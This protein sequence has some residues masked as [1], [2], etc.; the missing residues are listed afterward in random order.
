MKR[1]LY[2]LLLLPCS[3]LGDNAWQYSGQIERS[4]VVTGT[5]EVNPDGSVKSYTL[6]QQDKLLPE[7]IELI[8]KAVPT[9]KFEPMADKTTPATAT[10]NI[11][12]IADK[13]KEDQYSL[14]ICGVSFGAQHENLN[15]WPHY[16]TRDP[17]PRYPDVALQRWVSGTVYVAVLVNRQGT[18]EKVDAMRVD[19]RA[20]GDRQIMGQLRRSLAQS[21]L[22]AIAKWTFTVPT[23]GP[24]VN[25]DHWMVRI[26]VNFKIAGRDPDTIPYGHWDAYVPGPVNHVSWVESEEHLA[27]SSADAIPDNDFAFQD[28]PRFVLLNAPG[29]G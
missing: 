27:E 16:K 12:V 1:L 21:A 15:E 24:Y 14:S 2:L 26:P 25:E 7:I 10:M 23:K 11:R 13:L 20:L 6:D 18:V 19:L 5:V 17:I 8:T 22:K 4:M 9:W 3:V 28:D 29:N